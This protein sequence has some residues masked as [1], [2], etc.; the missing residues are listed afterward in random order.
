MQSHISIEEIDLAQ[1]LFRMTHLGLFPTT[2]GLADY[3]AANFGRR[4]REI[5]NELR[6]KNIE[7]S[8]TL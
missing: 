1:E 8:A 6:G 4:Y 3:L 5:D 7:L 2:R